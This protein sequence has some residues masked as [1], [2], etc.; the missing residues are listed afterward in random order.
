MPASSGIILQCLPWISSENRLLSPHDSL[1][2]KAYTWG[3]G[4]PESSSW[5]QDTTGSMKENS[6][7]R[8]D[9]EP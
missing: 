5:L 4:D 1:F 2:V 8:R 9:K 7:K 6:S 3:V